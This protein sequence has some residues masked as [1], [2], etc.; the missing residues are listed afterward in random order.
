MFA[1]S[2]LCSLYSVMEY[3]HQ[4]IYIFESYADPHEAL[5]DA[6]GCGPVQFNIVN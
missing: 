2:L 4:V 6:P 1:M 3:L 5:W